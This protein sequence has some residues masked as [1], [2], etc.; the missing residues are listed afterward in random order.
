MARKIIGRYL[1]S[2][3]VSIIGRSKIKNKA[4]FPKNFQ[5]TEYR[6]DE[7]KSVYLQ[8]AEIRDAWVNFQSLDDLTTWLED[9]LPNASGKYYIRCFAEWHAFIPQP[10]TKKRLKRKRGRPF[11]K[12]E[13]KFRIGWDIICAFAIESGTVMRVFAH[14]RGKTDYS[15]K[16]RNAYWLL[17]AIQDQK[18]GKH[19]FDQI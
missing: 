10:T 7:K 15:P 2:R 4:N 3:G 8:W 17:G 11:S 1:L 16:R 18:E 6:L 14:K 5:K 19:V 13:R 12:K 9:I